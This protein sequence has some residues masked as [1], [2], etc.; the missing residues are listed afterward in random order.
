MFFVLIFPTCLF[1]N[2]RH[3]VLT[4]ARTRYKYFASGATDGFELMCRY[5]EKNMGLLQEQ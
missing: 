5:W 3:I 2:H 4:E 1:V